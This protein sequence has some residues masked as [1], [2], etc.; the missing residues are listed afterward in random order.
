MNPRLQKLCD[1]RSKVIREIGQLKAEIGSN[2]PTAAD[3]QTLA[4]LEQLRTDLDDRIARLELT[5]AEAKATAMPTDPG[6]TPRV[7]QSHS[8]VRQMTAVPPTSGAQ[9]FV[10]TFGRPRGQSSG[11]ESLT[12]LLRN[13]KAGIVDERMSRVMAAHGETTGSAGGILVPDEFRPQYFGNLYS[14]G[15]V[16]PLCQAV[17]MSGET[18]TVPGWDDSTAAAGSMFGGIT[19]SIVSEG[20]TIPESTGKMRAIKLKA[21]KL[22]TYCKSSNELETDA[23]SA[24]WPSMLIDAMTTVAS[25]ELDRLVL[26]GTGSGEPLGALN[27][28]STITASK[29]SGQAAKTLTYANVLDMWARLHPG[30]SEKAVWFASPTVKPSLETLV[31]IVGTSGA[32]VRAITESEGRSMLL[33]RPIVYTEHCSALGELGDIILM[34][35]R[36]YFIG[37]R[38]DVSIEASRHVAFQSDETGWRSIMRVDGCPR[39]S[40]VYTPRQGS[41]FSWSVTLEAR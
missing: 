35:P 12:E 5:L 37:L 1:D 39:W 27:A 13:Y 25:Y 34:A 3:Q 26:R 18:T 7:P 31:I 28:A 24:L 22:G 41:T 16:W 23:P 40:S 29:Q 15:V 19:C 10:E 38:Q 20:G 9:W 32:A 30:L 21:A 33:G 8:V 6:I 36:E 11:F 4:E 17:P 14:T 2:K